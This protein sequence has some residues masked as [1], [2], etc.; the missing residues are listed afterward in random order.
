M[1][2]ECVYITHYLF[3]YGL[4]NL[5]NDVYNRTTSLNEILQIVDKVFIPTLVSYDTLS[6]EEFKSCIAGLARFLT[7]S[8]GLFFSNEQNLGKWV[9]LLEHMI[10][11]EMKRST[12]RLWWTIRKLYQTPLPVH[13]IDDAWLIVAQSLVKL[14]G[15]CSFPLPINGIRVDAKKWISDRFK[16]YDNINIE[17]LQ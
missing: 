14:E 5:I 4:S 15:K 3:K 2:E 9:N 7:E 1:R 6:P 10:T 12:S 13:D 11:A 8:A 16:G 17:E